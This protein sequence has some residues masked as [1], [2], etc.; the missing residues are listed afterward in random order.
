MGTILRKLFGGVPHSI[1]TP[2][3]AFSQN[4]TDNIDYYYEGWAA[5]ERD[6]GGGGAIVGGLGSGFLLGLIGWAVGLAIVANQ[7]VEV[8]YHYLLELSN[9][10]RMRFEQGYKDAVKK[11]RNGNF[12]VGAG[13]G[14]LSAVIFMLNA[15]S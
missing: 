6:Y 9:S 3:I 8:P 12:N 4:R 11:K 2:S 15:S 5:A 1:L 7:N 13:L 14:T 10:D